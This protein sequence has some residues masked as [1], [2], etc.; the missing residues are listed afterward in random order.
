MKRLTESSPLLGME[1]YRSLRQKSEALWCG[2]KK[3]TEVYNLRMVQPHLN[4]IFAH[5]SAYDLEN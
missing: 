3:N 1:L 4:Y 5:K 2:E